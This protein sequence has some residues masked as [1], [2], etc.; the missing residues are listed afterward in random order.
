MVFDAGTYDT[1]KIKKESVLSWYKVNTQIRE[2]MINKVQINNIYLQD[3]F[4]QSD[5]TE[6]DVEIFRIIQMPSRSYE[7]DD[8]V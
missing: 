7:W 3:V 5:G 1:G 4:I 6:E 8:N 2:S